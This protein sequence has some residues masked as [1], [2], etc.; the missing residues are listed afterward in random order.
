MPPFRAISRGL[1][2]SY[3]T[4]RQSVSESIV[5]RYRNDILRIRQT[6][7]NGMDVPCRRIRDF[8]S[9]SAPWGNPLADGWHRN[10]GSTLKV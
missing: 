2:S 1:K 4:G 6:F 7:A 5:P 9:Q 3:G 8:G 10:S